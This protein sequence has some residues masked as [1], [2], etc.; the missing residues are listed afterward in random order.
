MRIT[1][2][3]NGRSRGRQPLTIRGAPP[4]AIYIRITK[5][6]H[7]ILK[8]GLR[9]GPHKGWLEVPSASRSDRPAGTGS[10]GGDSTKQVMSEI[11]I[12]K[13]I[14][15]NSAMLM[16]LS[17]TSEGLKV[18]I[19]YTKDKGDDFLSVTL[20][21]AKISSYARGGGRGLGPVENITI[22]F[23]GA[24]YD[25][26]GIGSDITQEFGWPTKTN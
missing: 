9:D 26:H 15:M 1:L 5:D 25:K 12:T 6:G 17:T 16:H 4:M 19:D 20:H 2:I 10:G 23:K 24:T 8:G 7:P 21:E 14:D 22:N 13:L 18:E 11:Q 3:A